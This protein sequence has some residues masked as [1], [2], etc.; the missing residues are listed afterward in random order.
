MLDLDD[1]VRSPETDGSLYSITLASFQGTPPANPQ[2]YNARDLSQRVTRETFMSVWIDSFSKSRGDERSQYL[3]LEWLMANNG[4]DYRTTL[5]NFKD[6]G[7]WNCLSEEEQKMFVSAV[8]GV[9]SHRVH[10]GKPQG[11]Y[12]LDLVVGR[13]RRFVEMFAG[14]ELNRYKGLELASLVPT[15]EPLNEMS[16]KR[17]SLI[18]DID[19]K[20]RKAEQNAQT[21]NQSK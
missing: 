10:L 2:P 16:L 13:F 15:D 18:I 7:S 1:A 14:P 12:Y 5:G 21:N 17:L 19:Y 3:F 8:S 9:R 20:E 11:P 6:A 4:H